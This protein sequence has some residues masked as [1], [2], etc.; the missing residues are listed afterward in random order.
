MTG[1]ASEPPGGDSGALSAFDQLLLLVGRMN[2]SWTNTESLLIHLIA[3]LAGTSK[4]TAVIIYLT[5][6]TT[7]ARVDLVDR[8]AKSG[9]ASGELRDRITGLTGRI[10]KHQSLRNHYSHSIYSFDAETGATRTITMRIADRKN[11]LKMGRSDDV[12]AEALTRIR[13]TI[14]AL[15]L[16]NHEIWTL[17]LEE[18]Y[19]V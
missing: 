15:K 18:G 9:A 10:R 16:L 5:L 3:G 19:P 6:N 11:E 7:R 12:D 1:P 8:L 14:E 2:Y 17:V 4:Q 13:Q